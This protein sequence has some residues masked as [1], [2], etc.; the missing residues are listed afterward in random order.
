MI[1]RL[2]WPLVVTIVIEWCMLLYLGERRRKVLWGSVVV[3][4]LTNV[5]LNLF[6]VYVSSGWTTVVIGELLVVLIEALWYAWLVNDWHQSLVYSVLCNA[7]SF[8]TGLLFQ[9]IYLVLNI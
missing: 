4:V 3:N 5:P 7:V 1:M 8:L 6:A 2:L 9:L